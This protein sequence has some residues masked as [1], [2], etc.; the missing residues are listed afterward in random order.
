LWLPITL[1][2]FWYLAREGLRWSDFAAA[3]RLKEQEAHS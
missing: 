1:L 2:G 3:Q